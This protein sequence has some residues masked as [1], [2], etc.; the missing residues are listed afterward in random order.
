MLSPSEQFLSSKLGDPTKDIIMHS[1]VTDFIQKYLV[2]H[3]ILHF[4]VDEPD[5]DIRIQKVMDQTA[6]K[7]NELVSESF[8]ADKYYFL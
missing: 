3:G 2:D 4:V 1:K 7:H 8:L 5:F 6:I